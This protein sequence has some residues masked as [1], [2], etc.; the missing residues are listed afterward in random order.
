MSIQSSVCNAESFAYRGYGSKNP[1][2][3]M[4]EQAAV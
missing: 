1:V 3:E 4:E 2:L